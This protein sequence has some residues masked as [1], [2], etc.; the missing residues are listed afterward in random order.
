MAQKLGAVVYLDKAP[1]KY[2]GLTYSE[3]WISEAQERM[4]LAVP[5]NH[6]PVLS[7]L[8]A[9]EDVEA[10]VIGAFEATH[11]LRLYYLE[12]QV[13]DLDMP[14]LHD[15]R[16]AVVRQATWQAGLISPS[17]Q[18]LPPRSDNF[19]SALLH[20][21]SSLNVCSKEWIIRQY[22]H[23]VQGGTVLKPLVGAC[24]DGPGDA[25]VITPVLGSQIGLAI[26]CGINQR[27]GDLDPYAMAAAAIDEAARNVIAVGADPARVALLD[28][29][30]WG[31]TD[32]LEVLGALVRAAEACRDVALAY[33]MPFISGK[34]SLNNEFHSGKTHI[35]IPPTLLISAMGRVPDMR[36]CLT[37]D[38]KEA[39]NLLY[40]IGKTR[41]ELGGSHHHLVSGQDGGTVP[42]VDLELAPRIFRKLH[43][44]MQRGLVRSCHDLSEGGLAVAVAEMAFAGGVGAD[45]TGLAGLAGEADATLLF[46]EST[47]RFLVEVVPESAAPLEECFEGLPL[48]RVGQTVQ[49][50][51]L[52]IAGRQGDWIIC[53]ALADLKEAWQKPLRT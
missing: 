20:I 43:E 44:A 3:I 52:R 17:S 28:N 10:T 35:T 2:E 37:M 7:A 53:A 14:F 13:A 49:E 6:W 48:T 47:T 21:L 4:V 23:E 31:N 9:S 34:D 18:T 25:A 46:S 16:P 26:G 12:H 22:D 27:Y 15:G 36:R 5:P 19:T 24:D 33:G 39:G 32:Q 42:E 40:L 38:L 29:F 1:L 11:K 8:C 45:V 51:R 41:N 30:C 50:P